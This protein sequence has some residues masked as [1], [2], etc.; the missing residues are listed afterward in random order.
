M[1]RF[2]VFLLLL[3][4]LGFAWGGGQKEAEKGELS[5]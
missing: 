4:V 2:I 5:T 1:K 3:A